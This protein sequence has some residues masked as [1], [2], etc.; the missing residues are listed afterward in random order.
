LL[1]AKD[2]LP[3]AIRKL[4][5]RTPIKEEEGGTRHVQ[6]KSDTSRW[7]GKAGR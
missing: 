5:E 2:G 3:F 1:T 7:E 6:R 4:K